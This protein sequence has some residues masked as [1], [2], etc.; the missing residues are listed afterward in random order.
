V[1]KYAQDITNDITRKFN[2]KRISRMPSY[3]MKGLVVLVREEVSFNPGD[4]SD[5]FLQN[6]GS[7]KTHIASHPRRRHSS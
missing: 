7:H 3:G 6:F 2:P 5:M 1:G 4:E